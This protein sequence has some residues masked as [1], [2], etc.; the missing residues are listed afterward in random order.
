MDDNTIYAQRRRLRFEAA[1]VLMKHPGLSSYGEAYALMAKVFDCGSSDGF[2]SRHAGG[3][4]DIHEKLLLLTGEHGY[5]MWK[6][7]LARR[8]R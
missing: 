7:L 3:D 8:D 1:Q 6:A 2:V 4:P 5:V